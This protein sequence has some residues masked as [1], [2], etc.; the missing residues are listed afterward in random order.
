MA[1]GGS[2][3]DQLPDIERVEVLN[4]PQGTLFGKNASIGLINITTKK[5]NHEETEAI[6]SLRATDDD[7]FNG[8]F[9]YSAPLNDSLAFRASGFWRSYGG[10][11]KNIVTREDVNGVDALGGRLRLSWNLSDSFNAL[12]SA[13]YSRQITECCAR[14][15]REERVSPAE[16]GSRPGTPDIDSSYVNHRGGNLAGGALS[17][18]AAE[19]LGPAITIGPENDRIAQ[20]YDPFQESINRGVALELN[21]TLA[22]E[23][24]L[25]SLTAYREWEAISGWDND[26]TPF[27]FQQV[28]RSDRDVDWFSQEIRLTSPAENRFDYLLGLYYYTSTTDAT[29]ISDRIVMDTGQDQ[30]F[31]VLAES[32]YDNIAA[33][34]HVNFDVT[35]TFTLFGGFRLLDEKAHAEAQ[36]A[37]C[38]GTG[39]RA[40]KG[41]KDPTKPADD[42]DCATDPVDSSQSDTEFLYKVGAQ[43]A[44]SDNANLYSSYSTGYKGRGFSLEYGLSTE[45]FENGE[46]PI[47][48]E[49]S[50]SL[51]IGLKG[52]IADRARYSLVLFHTEIEGFQKSLRDLDTISN[53]LGSVEEITTRGLEASIDAYVTDGLRLSLS[54][55]YLDAHYSD[56]KNAQ[57]YLGQTAEQGC[58]T[59]MRRD[60]VEGNTATYTLYDRTDQVL[61]A[62]PEHRVVVSGR[63]ESQGPGLRFFLQSNY[64]WQ[65]EANMSNTG[66]PSSVQDSFGILDMSLGLIA[67]D[68]KYTLSLFG[69]NLTDEFYI[70]G[71]D[72]NGADMGGVVIHYLPRDYYR[73]FGISL[74]YRL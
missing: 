10:N 51:E 63:Y 17:G 5:P 60:P 41:E 35:D 48:G 28:Q 47:P 45:R 70:N 3:F 2:A 55:A 38:S 9:G 4:G 54:Y 59:E 12:F 49:E 32:G 58:M 11:V 14:I 44:L 30:M 6:L 18:T 8:K 34:G 26:F 57:C 50:A 37:E 22:N 15:H 52:S 1:R 56:F 66:E 25:T 71:A 36:W 13:D 67:P 73:Y 74:D 23:V 7:D 64:R 62:S 20:D 68:D 43:W 31:K 69:K 42:F 61:E 29:E 65:D 19:V 40:G 53:R 16:S 39:A 27:R 72:V 46:E 24:T 21:T 33:F